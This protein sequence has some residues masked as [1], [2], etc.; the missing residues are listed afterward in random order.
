[1]KT[2]LRLD[3]IDETSRPVAGGKA[4]ALATVARTGLAV[5]KAICVAAQVYDR[6]LKDTGLRPRLVMEYERKP[7]DQM[8]WEEIW[9]T[10]LRIQNLFIHTEFP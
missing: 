7:F 6:F 8:R 4:V 9:D 1:M 2:I 5:P 10:A 3:E